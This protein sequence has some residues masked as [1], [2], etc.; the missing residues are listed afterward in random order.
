MTTLQTP[1][2]ELVD[3]GYRALLREL[4]PA[5]FIQFIQHF[6]NGTGD[7]TAERHQWLTESVDEIFDAMKSKSKLPGVGQ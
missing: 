1:T 3:R 4:G 6:R 5:G 2:A 7:Y